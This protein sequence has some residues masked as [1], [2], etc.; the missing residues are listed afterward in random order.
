[1]TYETILESGTAYRT[2]AQWQALRRRLA[3][4]L[5]RN[6]VAC[7]ARWALYARVSQHVA[8]GSAGVAGY[9]RPSIRDWVSAL[10]GKFR[11]VSSTLLIVG[12]VIV[13]LG[14]GLM[15]APGAG[16]ATSPESQDPSMHARAHAV[17]LWQATV[18]VN[19]LALAEGWYGGPD[20]AG[21]RRSRAVVAAA[22]VR[23]PCR[24]KHIRALLASVS[25]LIDFTNTPHAFKAFTEEAYVSSFAYAAENAAI[26]MAGV[27]CQ[28]GEG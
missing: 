22:S 14:L 1:M 7:N 28:G 13:G 5:G 9:Y 2:F 23:R 12:L 26:T 25:A 10:P 6:T 20:N 4:S 21:L 19:A 11:K 24:R 8:H 16:A 18:R 17:H 15:I 3:W 27:A